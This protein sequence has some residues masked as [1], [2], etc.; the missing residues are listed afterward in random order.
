MQLWPSTATLSAAGLYLML[1][2][3]HTESDA[4]S[5]TPSAVRG[6]PAAK[7]TSTRSVPWLIF[8]LFQSRTRRF[9]T[10][11]PLLTQAATRDINSSKFPG[12]SS[13]PL[14][15]AR[16]LAGPQATRL[17]VQVPAAISCILLVR[18]VTFPYFAYLCELL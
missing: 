9:M 10:S 14:R 17:W 16:R 15:Q 18:R 12:P 4:A 1:Y 11:S 7:N 3:I 6:L 2:V 5:L 13:L 8:L